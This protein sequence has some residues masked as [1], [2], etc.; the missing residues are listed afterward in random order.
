MESLI[1]VFEIRKGE[2]VVKIRR[3]AFSA[4]SRRRFDPE[5][6]YEVPWE[7]MIAEAEMKL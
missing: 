6:P 7:E 2:W 1:I 4:R 5:E 3:G